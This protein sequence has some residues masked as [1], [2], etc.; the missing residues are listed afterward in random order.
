MDL[1]HSR[2][3]FMQKSAV[4]ASAGAAM[5]AHFGDGLQAAINNGKTRF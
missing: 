5:L 2:R 1:K 4:A 3:S